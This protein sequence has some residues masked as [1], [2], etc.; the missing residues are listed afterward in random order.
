MVIVGSVSSSRKQRGWASIVTVRVL[1]RKTFVMIQSCC[2]VTHKTQS[3]WITSLV[4][5][6]PL[7]LWCSFWLDCVVP[8][9]DPFILWPLWRTPDSPLV[10][11]GFS[12]TSPILPLPLRWPLS[13]SEAWVSKSSSPDSSEVSWL[14]GTKYGFGFLL[15]WLSPLL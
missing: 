5:S 3:M 15:V 7:T 12:R 8:L 4:A 2:L 11:W 9:G 6:C 13:K 1:K 10:T 14:Y